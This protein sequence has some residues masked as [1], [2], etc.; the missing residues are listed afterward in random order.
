MLKTINLTIYKVMKSYG[1][2]V[3]YVPDNYMSP[4][5]NQSIIQSIN[6]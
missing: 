4:P 5:F 3:I 2:E 6:Q 1:R